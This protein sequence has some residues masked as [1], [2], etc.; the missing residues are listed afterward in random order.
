MYTY[1]ISS[2]PIHA[3]FVLLSDPPGMLLDPK[4]QLRM[5]LKRSPLYDITN[6]AI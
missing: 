3:T 5:E 2:P 1:M 4:K 6:V